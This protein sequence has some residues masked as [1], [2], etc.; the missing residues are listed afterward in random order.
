[1]KLASAPIDFSGIKKAAGGM[2]V[3]EIYAQKNDLSS[4]Q[5]T[6]RARL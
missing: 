2:T 3:A 5:V 4:K 6:V 1:M